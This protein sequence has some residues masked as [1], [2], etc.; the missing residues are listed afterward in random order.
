[1]VPHE[2]E[3]GKDRRRPALAVTVAHTF[4]RWFGSRWRASADEHRSILHG[5]VVVSSFVL[6]AKAAGAAKEMAVAWRYGVSAEVDAYLLV[7]NLVTL[8]V[9]VWFSV[10]VVILIP[11]AARIRHEAPGE[12]RRF[13][14][15]LLGLTLVGG[16]ILAP[17][18]FIGLP[19][20]LTSAWLKLP[21]RT[22]DLATQMVPVLAWLVPLGLLIALYSTWTMS[23]RRHLNTLLE[24]APAVGVLCAVLLV[25][26]IE[27]LIWGTLAGTLVQLGLLVARSSDPVADVRPIF[28]V[29]SPQ[30]SLFWQGFGVVMLGQAIMSLTTVID[31]FFA[32]RLGQG[33]ISSLGYAGRILA[34]ALSLVATAVTRSTLPVFSHSRATA[35]VDARHLAFRWAAL[36]ALAG[37]VILGTGW[38]LAPWAVRLLYQRGTFSGGD[39]EV[40]ARL[41]RFG[42]LQVP[43]YLSSLVL[44]SLHSSYGR[45]RLLLASG[46][47]GLSAKVVANFL[48]LPQF[49]VGALMLSNAAVYAANTVLLARTKPE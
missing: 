45:Y 33:A 12:L 3:E 43:F 18:G 19:R 32:A 24:G 7:L 2:R 46:V 17:A 1:M 27:P 34:L 6:V 44:V 15:E 48:L 41:L 47:V 36:L 31:Q 13:R 4:D 5:M 30:W 49:N 25:G 37:I 11:L 8:P 14:A 23:A 22:V 10:L 20:L 40:V 26:G 29:S 42:L 21:G 39:T 9:S 16:A 28:S 38:L 35:V